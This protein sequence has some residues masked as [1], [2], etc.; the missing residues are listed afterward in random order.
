MLDYLKAFKDEFVKV[1][2]EE[3]PS[4]QA[5]KAPRASQAPQASHALKA[6]S[7]PRIAKSE[8]QPIYCVNCGCA[9]GATAKYCPECGTPKYGINPES[10]PQNFPQIAQQDLH[11]QINALVEEKIG[12]FQ[13]THHQREQL[14]AG[15]IQKCPNCGEAIDP[16]DAV[17]DF[18]GFRITGR[19][20]SSVVQ[21]FSEGLMQIEHSRPTK[22]ALDEVIEALV[23]SDEDRLIAE[24]KAEFIR[25][26]PVPNTVEEL[27]EFM[28]MADS[29]ISVKHSKKRSFLGTNYEGTKEKMVSDAW[30]AKMQQVF[31]KA[32]LSFSDDPI[33]TEIK[34]IYIRKTA[35]LGLE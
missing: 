17:C 18:C 21:R 2:D 13:P 11:T 3:N 8:A 27:T 28:F 6:S 1:W 15:V 32:K 20:S 31:K 16:T 24:K 26:F 29:N 4:R 12:A 9:F 25:S 34:E 14:Y 5:P 35:E 22:N 19:N 7:A 10:A 30:V 23:G 33:F